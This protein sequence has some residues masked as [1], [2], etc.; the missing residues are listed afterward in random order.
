MID[1]NKLKLVCF[2]LKAS[3]DVRVY[4]CVCALPQSRAPVWVPDRGRVMSPLLLLVL[5]LLLPLLVLVLRGRT[6]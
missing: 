3:G 1:K 2:I 5:G 6:R 4:K